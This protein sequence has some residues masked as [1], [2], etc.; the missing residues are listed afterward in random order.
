MLDVLEVGLSGKCEHAEFV[1]SIVFIL[2]AIQEDGSLAIEGNLSLPS[3]YG[4][5]F[6]LKFIEFL[7][8]F[9]VD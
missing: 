9:L 1:E 3:A 5:L 4:V 8:L 2:R 7:L 6:T